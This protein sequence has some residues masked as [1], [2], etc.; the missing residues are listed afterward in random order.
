MVKNWR[1]WGWSL[2][3]WAGIAAL[4]LYALR[5]AQLVEIFTVLKRLKAGQIAALMV[6]NVVI[7]FLMNAR[8]WL[9]LRSFGYKRPLAALLAYRL[10]AFGISYFTPGPQFGGEPLQVH[11]LHHRQAVPLATAIST[12]FL[13]RLLDLLS[14]FTFLMVGCLVIALGNL[15][16]GPVA[17]FIWI[18]AAVL[19]CLPLFH[20]IALWRGKKPAG[21]L[22]G[23]LTKRLTRPFLLRAS[24]VARQSENQVVHLMRSRPGVL[25]QAI[26]LSLAVWTAFVF[27]FWLTL[28]FIGV[29]AN[30]QETISA[31]TAARIA[32]LLPFP[33]GL[34]ALEVSQTLAARM[35]GWGPASAVA[36]TLII[37][38]RDISLGLIGLWLGGAAYRAFLTGR[39]STRERRS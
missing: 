33:G 23:R 4:L 16:G 6:V 26:G 5:D 29:A 20:L 10:A 8:W 24:E 21:W 3:L 18:F 22:F 34:G 28:N 37:R 32:Y 2:F 36:L 12:V 9:L 31:L 13:D 39:F 11:L 17:D 27:E 1:G 19:L 30:L 25:F 7:L 14:N 15:V 35:L 38:A